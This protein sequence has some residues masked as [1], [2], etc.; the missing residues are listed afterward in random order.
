MLVFHI[1]LNLQ[2]IADARANPE[3]YILFSLCLISSLDALLQP[4]VISIKDIVF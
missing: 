2:D 4:H 3:N 1:P